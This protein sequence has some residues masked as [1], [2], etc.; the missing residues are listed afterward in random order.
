[1]ASFKELYKAER[2]LAVTVEESSMS[3]RMQQ[4]AAYD[5]VAVG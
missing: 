4:I 1:M 2:S 3:Y 5:H